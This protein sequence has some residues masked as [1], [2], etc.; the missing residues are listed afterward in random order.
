MGP[1][2]L[3]VALESAG[4]ALGGGATLFSRW[5]GFNVFGLRAGPSLMYMYM[6]MFINMYV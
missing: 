4:G 5:A 6:C 2:A 3:G 1:G